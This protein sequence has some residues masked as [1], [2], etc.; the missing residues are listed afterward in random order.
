MWHKVVYWQP[1]TAFS[2]WEILQRGSREPNII[3]GR[4]TEVFGDIVPC[5][6]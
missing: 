2:N 3:Y 4:Y 5:L 1:S 6:G